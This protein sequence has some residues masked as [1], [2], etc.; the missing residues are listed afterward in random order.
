[1][2][3]LR[4]NLQINGTVY[5]LAVN[6]YGSGAPTASTIGKPGVLYL[7]TGNG[8]LYKCTA[9]DT[10]SGVYTWVAMVGAGGVFATT[11]NGGGAE[12]IFVM[13]LR[14]RKPNTGYV[15]SVGDKLITADN[16]LY[17]ITAI[18][19]GLTGE[20]TAKLIRNLN[21]SDEQ[22]RTLDTLFQLVSYSGD[23]TQA[24]AD[25]RTA[26]GIGG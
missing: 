8:N 1:V 24:L 2:S 20:Y 25:F 11:V 4:R 19:E 26:F 16:Y 17:E 3:E 5:P 7:N 6:Q 15:L 9:A 14:I 13:T 12:E 10:A 18:P 21:L 23:A 22:I